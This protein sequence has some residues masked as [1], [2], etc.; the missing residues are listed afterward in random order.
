MPSAEVADLRGAMACLFALGACGLAGRVAPIAAQRPVRAPVCRA[1]AAEPKAALLSMLANVDARGFRQHDNT[2][3]APEYAADIA[4]AVAALEPLDRDAADWMVAEFLFGTSWRLVYTSSKTLA[5]NGGLSGLA[6]TEGVE[7]P[8][9]RMRLTETPQRM[10]YEEDLSPDS[11]SRLAAVLGLPADEPPPRRVR[12]DATW[13]VGGD[14]AML[15]EG[16]RIGVGSR[17]WAPADARGQ[18]CAPR[19]AAAPLRRNLTRRRLA[20]YLRRAACAR[21]RRTS[22]SIATRQCARSVRAVRSTSTPGYS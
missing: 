14:D 2:Y 12:I 17:E 6:L 15:V 9:L 18:A 1:D 20:L 8:E 3:R 11:G 13:R 21:R 16:F 7:T 10:A 19:A 5:R 22:T 4:D